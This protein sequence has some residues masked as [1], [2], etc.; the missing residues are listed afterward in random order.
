MNVGQ[1]IC[2]FSERNTKTRYYVC[3]IFQTYKCWC[4]KH[5]SSFF[6][7]IHPLSRYSFIAIFFVPLALIFNEIAW[8]MQVNIHSCSITVCL[9]EACK[10][11]MFTRKKSRKNRWSKCEVTGTGKSRESW[12]MLCA[13]SIIDYQSIFFYIHPSWRH[14]VMWF[15]TFWK[16][17]GLRINVGTRVI[18][19]TSKDID[20]ESIRSQNSNVYYY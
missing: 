5:E 7:N 3:Y 10:N 6:W 9:G 19:G 16:G 11:F 14:L 4:W 15:Q 20:F 12:A 8:L 1:F 13:F 18:L 2:L 17:R